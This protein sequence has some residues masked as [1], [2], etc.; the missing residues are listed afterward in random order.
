ATAAIDISD[1][2]LQDLSHILTQ[3]DVGARVN[4]EALP[5]SPE[6][7]TKLPKEKCE[8]LALAG[9]EDFELCF[10]LPSFWRQH[11]QDFSSQH[12]LPITRIGSIEASPGLNLLRAGQNVTL[13]TKLGWQHF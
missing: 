3:S 5:I 8:E 4:L 6:L 13:P 9:G 11:L 10:T 1:G 12:N 7:G 2:L